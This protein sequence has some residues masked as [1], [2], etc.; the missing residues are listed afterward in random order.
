MLVHLPNNRLPFS[1]DAWD[2]L[3]LTRASRGSQM[4]SRPCAYTLLPPLSQHE[5]SNVGS[6]QLS[7][8]MDG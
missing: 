7:I 6:E 8:A 2:Q 1:S 4:R 5:G 3:L